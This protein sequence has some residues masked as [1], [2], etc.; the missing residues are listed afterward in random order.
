MRPISDQAAI[1]ATRRA[2]QAPPWIDPLA[3][4]QRFELDALADTQRLDAMHLTALAEA[5]GPARPTARFTRVDTGWFDDGD[6]GAVTAE[7]VAPRTCR[8]T[9]LHWALASLAAAA[10]AAALYLF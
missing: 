10:A 6:S 4:T 7:M 8:A 9:P 3:D 1:R 5:A 2:A